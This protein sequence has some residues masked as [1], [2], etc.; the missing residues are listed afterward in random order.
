MRAKT[1]LMHEAH[2]IAV[3]VIPVVAAFVIGQIAT[4]PN[5]AP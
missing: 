4:Y 5:L 3:A 1:E 2:L